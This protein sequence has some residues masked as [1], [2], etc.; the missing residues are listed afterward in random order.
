MLCIHT[1][2]CYMLEL[3]LHDQNVVTEIAAVIS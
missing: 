1:V 3:S 2:V